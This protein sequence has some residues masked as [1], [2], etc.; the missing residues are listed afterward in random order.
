MPIDNKPLP[1]VLLSTFTQCDIAWMAGLLEGEGY[2]C[3]LNSGLG[4]RL[5]MTD[6]D[7]VKRFAQLWAVMPR[8]LSKRADHHKI[9]FL[10]SLPSQKAAQCMRLIRPFLGRR[11]LQTVD[12]CLQKYE[13]Q[14]HRF[15]EGIRL[16]QEKFTDAE[17]S[18]LWASRP[19]REA[20][21]PFCERVGLG[22]RTV[23]TRRL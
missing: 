4:V 1:D 7:I 23:V 9:P 14:Q 10:V 8:Q 12:D 11:R 2:F 17:F 18:A 16:R 21:R 13:Q 22:N 5:V 6:E 20:I 3:C 19:A 15:R